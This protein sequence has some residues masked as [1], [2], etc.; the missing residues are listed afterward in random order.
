MRE[1]SLGPW[2]KVCLT[3]SP[4][5]LHAHLANGVNHAT[6]AAIMAVTQIP[7]ENVLVGLCIPDA[8]N[9]G[10]HKVTGGRIV[11]MEILEMPEGFDDMKLALVDAVQGALCGTLCLPDLRVQ[12]G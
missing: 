1:P 9:S 5:F 8:R 4:P 6:K 7:E 3:A 12:Q 10:D 11:N 2:L